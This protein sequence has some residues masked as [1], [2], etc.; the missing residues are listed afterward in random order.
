[1]DKRT[2]S[3]AARKVPFIGDEMTARE[4]ANVIGVNMAWD[5][6]DDLDR[7]QVQFEEYVTLAERGDKTAAWW[8]GYLLERLPKLC[9]ENRDKLMEACRILAEANGVRFKPCAKG[10]PAFRGKDGYMCFQY[11]QALGK[12]EDDVPDVSHDPCVMAPRV[13][14]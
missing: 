4:K 9:A 10:V 14:L 8:V 7:A 6:A 2:D 12:T 3:D 1:M 13:T 5:V 11:P